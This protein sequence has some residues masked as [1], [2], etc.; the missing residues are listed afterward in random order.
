[1]CVCVCICMCVCVCVC[2]CVCVCGMCVSSSVRMYDGFPRPSY[3]YLDIIKLRA[4]L[5]FRSMY[6]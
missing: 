4:L 6:H 5:G 3:I 2:M 1:M